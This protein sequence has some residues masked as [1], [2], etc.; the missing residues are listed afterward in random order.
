MIDPRIACILT[1]YYKTSITEL[2]ECLLSIYSQKHFQPAEL[3]ICF[4]GLDSFH[5]LDEFLDPPVGVELR[6]IFLPQNAGPGKARHIGILSTQYNYIAIMDSDDICSDL[7]F[8]YHHQA[9]S[10]G[11]DFNVGQLAILSYGETALIRKTALTPTE[12]YS[13]VKFRTPF[14]NQTMAFSRHLYFLSGG[15]PDI[16]IAE[17]WVLMARLY[18]LSVSPLVSPK[19]FAFFRENASYSCRRTKFSHSVCEFKAACFVYLLGL[20]SLH[21]PL[22]VLLSRILFRNILPSRFLRTCESFFRISV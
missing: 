13:Y 6:T 11:C 8:Y 14:N 5:L 19:I 2:H 16:R 3:V 1:V 12:F 4:D 21:W 17:D 22:L 15:Y 10:A 9:F 18:P 20:S 7:R